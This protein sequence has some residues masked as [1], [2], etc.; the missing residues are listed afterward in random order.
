M[1]IPDRKNNLWF[2]FLFT[3]LLWGI[4]LTEQVLGISF[5]TY[6]ILPRSSEGLWGIF[7]APLLHE[8]MGH[9]FYNTVPLLT[10]LIL[11]FNFYRQVSWVVFILIYLISDIFI[12]LLARPY[13]HIGASILIYGCIGYFIAT[14]IFSNKIRYIFIALIVLLFYGS[15]LLG[16][17]PGTQG[18]S[19]EGHLIGCL[20][21]VVIAFLFARQH[22]KNPDR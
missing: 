12:W 20:V 5:S 14:G 6:G 10:L 1:A 3:L 22:Q 8:N 13:Y 15:S 2:P 9:L 17:L 4:K 7:L 18:I 16:I 19:W 11:L 21:G